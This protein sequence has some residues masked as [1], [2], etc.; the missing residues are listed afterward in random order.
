VIAALF[1]TVILPAFA[2]AILTLNDRA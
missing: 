2:V 1:F